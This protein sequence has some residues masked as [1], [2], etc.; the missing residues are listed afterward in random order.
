MT[1]LICQIGQFFLIFI[2]H[3]FF[4]ILKNNKINPLRYSH[5]ALS[6]SIQRVKEDIVFLTGACQH[7]FTIIP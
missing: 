4:K 2:F 6:F 5:Y 3:H 7:E 1:N